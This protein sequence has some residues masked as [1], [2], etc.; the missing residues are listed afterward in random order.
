MEINKGKKGTKDASALMGKKPYG[1]IG[2]LDGQGGVIE[3][4]KMKIMSPKGK[5]SDYV[6]G[7]MDKMKSISSQVSS[8]LKGSPMKKEKALSG[9]SY[10]SRKQLKKILEKK[11]HPVSNGIGVGP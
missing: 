6:K 2:P 8:S 10:P 4:I 3:S 1:S 9:D 5:V 7:A 11:D